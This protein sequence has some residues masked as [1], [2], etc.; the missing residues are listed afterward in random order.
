MRAAVLNERPGKLSIEDIEI[1]APVAGEIAIKVA[2]SGLCHSD[3]HCMDGA[4]TRPPVPAILGHELSGVVTEVGQ[5]VRGFEVGDH[6]VACLS[7]SCGACALCLSGQAWLCIDKAAT[8]RP[9]GAPSVRSRNG[10]PV[11]AHCNLGGMAEYVVAHES[12]FVVIDK[13]MPLD[14]ACIL[15]C[16]TVTGFG[17][18]TRSAQ[19]K[20][21]ETVA[22]LGCGGIGFNIIQ[23]ARISGASKIIAVDLN[24][25]KLGT[26]REL[27]ATHVVDASA[28]DAVAQVKELTGGVGVD[29]AF[30]AIGLTQTVRQSFAM[31]RVGGAAYVVGVLPA[32][33]TVEIPTD[34]LWGGG[35]RLQG[36]VMGSNNFKVD[37]P[38]YV[39]LYLQGRLDLEKMISRRLTLDEVNEGYDALLRG[40]V[41]RSIVVF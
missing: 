19:V 39:D 1:D 16:A 31:A 24:P 4:L 15:G 28:R 33:G 12:Q 18:V 10:E 2:A 13:A 11:S 9:E 17:A 21:G 40:E 29:H 3:I 34:D 41:N 5:G 20:V 7:M 23:G 30:E 26:A 38:A 37:I 27:G 32:G 22:V 36:V 8:A 35:K 6:V 14:I 25:A